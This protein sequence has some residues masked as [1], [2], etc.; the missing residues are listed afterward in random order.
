MIIDKF[1][2]MGKNWKNKKRG[3][4]TFCGIFLIFYFL[5][6]SLMNKNINNYFNPMKRKYNYIDNSKNKIVNYNQNQNISVF[7]EFYNINP[8]MNNNSNDK[9][10]FISKIPNSSVFNIIN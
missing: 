3:K 8:I 2:K 4:L 9:K 10:E 7:N 1:G 5:I 6:I